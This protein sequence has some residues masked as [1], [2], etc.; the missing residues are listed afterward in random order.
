MGDK[1]GGRRAGDERGEGD[2]PAIQ[3]VATASA[4]RPKSGEDRFSR[5]T[6]GA[7]AEECGFAGHFPFRHRQHN[8]KKEDFRRIISILLIFR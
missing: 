5:R 1:N 8:G 4:A 3:L 6:L 2:Q 7:D